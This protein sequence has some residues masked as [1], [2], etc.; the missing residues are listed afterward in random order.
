MKTRQKLTLTNELNYGEGYS[1]SINYDEKS[2]K[3][4]NYG[5]PGLEITADQ[6][7]LIAEKRPVIGAKCF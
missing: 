5:I 6:R 1:S 4:A 2:L 3:L 7:S